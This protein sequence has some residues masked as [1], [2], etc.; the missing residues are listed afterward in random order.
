[1]SFKRDFR[2]HSF[3]KNIKII[4]EFNNFCDKCVLI[5][6]S[7]VGSDFKINRNKKRF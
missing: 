6:K 4:E 1:M 3:I 7:L 5:L 2:S